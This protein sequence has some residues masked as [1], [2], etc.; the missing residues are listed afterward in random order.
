MDIMRKYRNAMKG[1]QHDYEFFIDQSGW[2]EHDAFIY[3]NNKRMGLT[4]VAIYDTALTMGEFQEINNY[5]I[6]RRDK[7]A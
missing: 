3:C 7:D 6:E 5:K 4:E 1:I 2:K